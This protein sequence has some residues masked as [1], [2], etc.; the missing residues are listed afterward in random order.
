ML[1][2][3]KKKSER[4]R[5]LRS[6]F[7]QERQARLNKYNGINLYVKNLEDA[8]DDERLIKEF[9]VYGAITS[10][11][12]MRDEKGNSKGFG[13]VCYRSHEEAS[14]AVTEMNGKIL[15]SKPLYVALAQRK[16]VRRAQ[17]ALLAQH[18]IRNSMISAPPNTMP[19]MPAPVYS[20]PPYAY[21]Q[22]Y[23]PS[24]PVPRYNNNPH[25]QYKNQ[26]LPD[27]KYRNNYNQR[28][29]YN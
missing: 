25:R 18:N 15:I 20:Y 1:L 17:L 5:E 6:K 2:V 13:F 28:N 19:Y 16:E 12:V 23:P 24:Q 8:F 26:R 4:I 11:K 27:D 3:L 14:K 10:A 7:E 22:M 9:S 29:A 21:P